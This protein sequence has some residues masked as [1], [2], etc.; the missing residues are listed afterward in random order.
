M[1]RNP[2]DDLTSLSTFIES[3]MKHKDNFRYLVNLDQADDDW[4]QVNLAVSDRIKHLIDTKFDGKSKN[5]ADRL[6]VSEAN[7]SGI[8]SGVQNFTLST[9][10]E[11]QQALGKNLLKWWVIQVARVQPHNTRRVEHRC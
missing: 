10:I 3:V 5:L 9:I 6:G 11:L 1:V 8:I 2:F 7:I 4:L